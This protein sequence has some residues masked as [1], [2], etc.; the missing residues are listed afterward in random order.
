MAFK[1]IDVLV[2]YLGGDPELARETLEELGVTE[3]PDGTFA[4]PFE[5]LKPAQSDTTPVQEDTDELCNLLGVRTQA[6]RVRTIGEG[7]D[8]KFSLI[9]VAML[10]NLTFSPQRRIRG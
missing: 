3:L 10:V 6:I 7:R 5:P 9:D 1:D 8:K 4:F 2:R